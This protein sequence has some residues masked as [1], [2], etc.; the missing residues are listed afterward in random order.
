MALTD[1]AAVSEVLG[2]S[3]TSTPASAPSRDATP[4]A[5]PAAP[6]EKLTTSTKSVADY[7]KEKLLAKSNAGVAASSAAGAPA[8]EDDR[9][10]R[11]GL[12]A[13]GLRRAW[14]GSDERADEDERPRGGLGCH[15]PTFT[16]M[17]VAS[18]T[19]L[20]PASSTSDAVVVES[21]EIAEAEAESQEDERARRKREKKARKLKATEDGDDGR[22][23]R[24]K[25]K[26]AAEKEELAS[27]SVMSPPEP[28]VEADADEP[29]SSD[30]SMKKKKK[31]GRK[32]EAAEESAVDE[33]APTHSPE[34]EE[35]RRVRRREKKAR[36][37]EK[38]KEEKRKS[39]T[40][41]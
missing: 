25:E 13:S 5:G 2:I 9:A 10:P 40:D 12:G 16:S 38:R 6:L 39:R 3:R 7:F 4:D 19:A 15:A 22:K 33:P 26:R 27:D 24:R 1:A 32:D 31:K 20:V 8:T 18:K 21:T 11:G 23:K 36:K 34:T 37:E 28:T 14:P 35:E 17:F 41:A 29:V 30:T